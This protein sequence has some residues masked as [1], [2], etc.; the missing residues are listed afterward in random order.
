[1]TKDPDGMALYA[2]YRE[3]SGPSARAEER[4]RPNPRSTPTLMKV[5][6]LAEELVSKGVQPDIYQGRAQ[7]WAQRL[8]LKKA[9]DA[10]LAATITKSRR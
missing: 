6:A 2:A 10:E 4:K 5:E 9:Y 8:D 1:M 7:V 3:A